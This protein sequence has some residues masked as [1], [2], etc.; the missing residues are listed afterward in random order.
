MIRRSVMSRVVAIALLTLSATATFADTTTKSDME[1]RRD[2]MLERIQAELGL[3]DQQTLEWGR[4]QD[5]YMVEHQRLRNEQ[6]AEINAMLTD[7][8]KKRFEKMQENFRKG[9][10]T[11]FK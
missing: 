4:I 6:N 1:M 2:L 7:E 8:Q 10:S 5:R 9:L 3:S 11:R